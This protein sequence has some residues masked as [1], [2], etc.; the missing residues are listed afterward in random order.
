M[1]SQGDDSPLPA[2]G[3]LTAPSQEDLAN[4][5]SEVVRL[6]DFL[7]TGEQDLQFLTDLRDEHIADLERQPIV[8][9]RVDS[10]KEG[11]AK[12][13]GQVRQ[14]VDGGLDKVRKSRSAFRK[15]S[16]R[17]FAESA[18][19]RSQEA[20]VTRHHAAI[21][22]ELV[23]LRQLALRSPTSGQRDQQSSRDSVVSAES[24]GPRSVRSFSTTS[25]K[26]DRP[27]FDNIGLLAD[28]MGDS[29]CEFGRNLHCS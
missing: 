11:A 12:A 23:H 10:V 25:S 7:Q 29:G 27:K 9:R 16:A 8:L 4:V 24:D 19:F 28:L 17:K 26:T 22:R 18:E 15:R 2:P 13:L 20:V 3:Q 1:P 6:L 14:V 5:P 21:L